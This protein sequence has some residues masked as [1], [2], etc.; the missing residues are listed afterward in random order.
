MSRQDSMDKEYF[1]KFTPTIQKIKI[2]SWDPDLSK[3]FA[4]KYNSRSWGEFQGKQVSFLHETKAGVFKT[5]CYRFHFPED[6]KTCF[7]TLT[8]HHF[9]VINLL[10]PV[11]RCNV[12]KN[13]CT[14]G[15]F[16]LEK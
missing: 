13:G 9:K 6:P 3:E 2:P 8:Y 5:R 11:C 12:W 4:D 14:C 16:Q 15:Q 7:A 1:L 10:K